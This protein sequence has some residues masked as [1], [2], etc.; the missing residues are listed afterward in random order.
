VTLPF[1]GMPFAGAFAVSLTNTT[2]TDITVSPSDCTAGLRLG[3]D[4]KKY[5]TNG[6][7]GGTFAEAVSAEW[8][9]PKDAQ[10]ADLYEC[11]ATVT[12]GALTSGTAGSWLALSS[13]RDWTVVRTSDLA[14]TDSCTFTLAIR[15]IG[16][17][18]NLASATITLNAEVTV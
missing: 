8:L 15:L 11:F 17:T 14:G 3:T 6:A 5:A 2:V 13:S 18:T 4:G 10:Q 12:G 7:G 1:F 9:Y 16:T